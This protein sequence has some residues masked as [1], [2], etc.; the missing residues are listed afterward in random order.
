MVAWDEPVVTLELPT[1]IL[2]EQL[3][4]AFGGP[5][6]PSEIMLW[7][8]MSPAQRRRA[9]KRLAALEVWLGDRG[10]A[11]ASDAAAAAGMDLS[12]FYRLAATWS[13][14]ES[15][16]LA[17]LGTAAAGPTRRRSRFDAE[18]LAALRERADR[19]VLADPRA[20]RSV[21]AKVEDL[22]AS[23]G[24]DV[25]T[26]PG[27]ATLRAIVDDARRRASIS[28]K[29]GE[30]LA[31][32]CCACSIRRPEG[33][34]HVLYACIDRAAGL[35]MGFAFGVVGDSV[36]GHRASAADAKARLGR[37]LPG[38][39]PWA[40]KLERAEAVIGTD[41]D[42]FRAWE[43]RVRA[44]LPGFNLQGS[45]RHRRFGRYLRQH[46]GHSVGRIVLLPNQ[47]LEDRPVGVSTTRDT[48]TVDEAR[49]RFE[50]EMADHNARILGRSGF[51]HRDLPLRLEMAL[52]TMASL[53]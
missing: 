33:T 21:E 39:I 52:R 18:L 28:W 51:E 1:E 38:A 43:V 20:E 3:T 48:F 47:T 9:V 45:N 25:T 23:I 15:R 40:E 41:L 46:V 12:R 11:K 49:V 44:A 2:D 26:R 36:A 35:I 24:P 4:K 53:A 8:S 13:D 42:A 6:P 10:A 34:A 29:V 5:L 22:A 37:I 16:S 19:L 31:F 7:A 14:R 17:V 27:R 50:V 32:D 30:D